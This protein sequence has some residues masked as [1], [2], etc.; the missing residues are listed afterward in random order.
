MG[1]CNVSQ[2]ADIGGVVEV[3]LDF[4]VEQGVGGLG[5]GYG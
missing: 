5:N 2:H 3:G 1:Q 4:Y